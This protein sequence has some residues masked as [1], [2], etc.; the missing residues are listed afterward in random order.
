MT[1]MHAGTNWV[2]WRRDILFNQKNSSSL[3]INM[4]AQHDDAC[5]LQASMTEQFAKLQP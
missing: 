2:S 3:E 4:E 1:D 5:M